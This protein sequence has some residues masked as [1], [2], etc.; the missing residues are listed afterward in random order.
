MPNTI[1]QSSIPVAQPRRGASL[2]LDGVFRNLQIHTIRNEVKSDIPCRM[3]NTPGPYEQESSGLA[4]SAACDVML[5]G[6]E[7]LSA[8]D[9]NAVDKVVSLLVAGGPDRIRG[10]NQ[11]YLTV[12]GA[13]SAAMSLQM[14]RAADKDVFRECL[15]KLDKAIVDIAVKSG[16]CKDA[17]DGAYHGDSRSKAL[18][19][20]IKKAQGVIEECFRAV[21]GETM[22][23]GVAEAILPSA[24]KSSIAAR[25]PHLLENYTNV[26]GA[27]DIQKV[28]QSGE[29]IGLQQGLGTLLRDG[30][31]VALSEAVLQVLKVPEYV[32]QGQAGQTADNAP[33]AD[34]LGPPAD[35]LSQAKDAAGGAPIAIN[36]APVAVNADFREL[37]GLLG[38]LLAQQQQP[39]ANRSELK[40]TDVHNFM[41]D[42]DAKGY[43]RG[44]LAA[45]AFFQKQQIDE[46][47]Q[48]VK[49][50]RQSRDNADL[51]AKGA[52]QIYV[53]PA[54]K[55]QSNQGTN[56]EKLKQDQRID[57]QLHLGSTG[58]VPPHQDMGQIPDTNIDK[59]E[60]RLLTQSGGTD[61]NQH[62]SG[63]QRDQVQDP[64]NRVIPPAG[65]PDR[66][67]DQDNGDGL[68][69]RQLGGDDQTDRSNS[70]PQQNLLQRGSDGAVPPADDLGDVPPVDNDRARVNLQLNETDR[71]DS[72]ARPAQQQRVGEGKQWLGRQTV[73]NRPL[74]AGAPADGGITAEF[75]LYLQALGI[76]QDPPL[77]DPFPTS[78]GRMYYQ[79]GAFVDGGPGENITLSPK[80]FIGWRKER[81]ELSGVPFASPS[82]GRQKAPPDRVKPELIQLI[83]THGPGNLSPK[84]VL[85]HNRLR[86][87]KATSVAIRGPDTTLDLAFASMR[88][89]R[90]EALYSAS[91]PTVRAVPPRSLSTQPGSSPV[92]QSDLMGASASLRS[93]SNTMTSGD[94][95][96]PTRAEILADSRSPRGELQRQAGVDQGL[97]FARSTSRLG[98]G[99]A[100][101]VKNSDPQPQSDVFAGRTLSSSNLA[102]TPRNEELQQPGAFIKAEKDGTAPVPR[103]A[104][105]V[106]L[107]QAVQMLRLRRSA[108]LVKTAGDVSSDTYS[109]APFERGVSE[110]S[111]DSGNGSPT[112]LN[113]GD[114]GAP[115]KRVADV[116]PAPTQKY[117]RM[118][119]LDLSF[120]ENHQVEVSDGSTDGPEE[121]VVHVEHHEHVVHAKRQSTIDQA[122]VT[123]WSTQPSLTAALRATP[124]V[125]I[126]KSA[127]SMDALIQELTESFQ[128]RAAAQAA[129]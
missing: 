76:K 127:D 36:H 2:S 15:G 74:G 122:P 40:L 92:V 94:V 77:D 54:G 121:K 75:K 119:D 6:R 126:S 81:D 114:W 7:A 30:S 73:S 87:A 102:P 128:K 38:K 69:H 85:D 63:Q 1:N 80:D 90:M 29:M 108:E 97:Q 106:A 32:K 8:S 57:S 21:G 124:S 59:A 104:H 68:V 33:P 55:D 62:S 95:R 16:K 23:R 28:L 109:V 5:R 91:T 41:K 100:Q 49:E 47:K 14:E 25:L 88:K 113:E 24:M 98:S 52:G 18:C 64:S 45:T 79:Q 115:V 93:L 70:R 42:V 117:P 9:R 71:T 103:S 39:Q 72:A 43:E 56:T 53:P 60:A 12:L 58:T 46:L 27:P 116:E 50:L 86:P 10:A 125:H 84:H 89:K 65:G 51:F 44:W 78:S 35:L 105:M 82:T 11:C 83:D 37:F 112:R 26:N 110:E 107:E 22:L 118:R 3:A 34:R 31:G 120:A 48:E 19:A 20:E 17:A 101:I 123:L 4:I 61:R 111:Q 129:T 67:P 13:M 66:K 96:S 99:V